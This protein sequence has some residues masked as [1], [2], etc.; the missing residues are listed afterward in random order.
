[1]MHITNNH[2][3]LMD[4]LQTFFPIAPRRSSEAQRCRLQTEGGNDK[5]NKLLVMKTTCL[6]KHS[7]LIHRL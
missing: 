2:I 7:K 1:M 6:G 3:V 5:L 4:L